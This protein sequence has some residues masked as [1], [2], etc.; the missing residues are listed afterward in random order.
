[1]RIACAGSLDLSPRSAGPRRQP[2]WAAKR[3]IMSWSRHMPTRRSRCSAMPD[4]RSAG[5]WAPFTTAATKPCCTRDS[6]LDAAAPPRLVELEL[7]GATRRGVARCAVTYWMNRL[8]GIAERKPA[9]R[10]AQSAPRA[11]I[12]TRPHV[13]AL[14]ASGVRCRGHDRAAASSGRCRAGATPGSAAHIS[15]PAFMR[16]GLQS[17]LAVAEALGGVRRPWSVKG[18]SGRIHLQSAALER[19]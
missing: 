15:A 5:C 19:I 18:Q 16:T 3:S 14:R 11:A 12:R 9:V 2:R 17:G 6:V 4:E 13:A 8:Q 1:M 7:H 10:H